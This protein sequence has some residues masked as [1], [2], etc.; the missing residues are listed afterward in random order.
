MG[1]EFDA[2]I[3]NGTWSLCPRPD[4]FHVVRNKWVYKIK[5][6]PEGQIDRYKARLVAKGFDQQY[7]IDYFETFSPVIKPSTIRVVLSLAVAFNWP[8]KQ[9][10]VSNAFLHGFLD[11]EVYME[12]PQGFIDESRP[13]Y[14][15][16]LHK[17][18]YGLKQAPRAWFQRFSTHL[19]DIG[20]QESS[21]DH[22]LFTLQQEKSKLFV[23]VYVDDIIV[24]GTQDSDIEDFIKQLQSTFQ[25]R[26]LGTLSYFIG[27]QASRN[28]EGLY[29]K[30]SK[31]ISDLLDKT[32]MIGARPLSTPTASG[33]KLSAHEGELLT[34]P[35]E[36]RQV[37]GALQYCTL[38]RPDI[39]YAVNQLCQFMHAPRE[40][41]WIATK[42]VL[43][44]LKGTIDYGI[45]YTQST[46]TL[47][48]FCDADWAGN[49]D[50]R[51]STSGYVV[52]LGQ[53]LISWSAKK[54]SV[55][56]KSST[57]AEYR[58]MALV[59]AELYWLRMLL[60]DLGI[61]L[62][63]PPTL[64]CDNVGAISL[65]SN[66]VFHAR[67]KHIEVDYHFI[68]EKVL[69]KDILVRYISTHD[70]IA[71]VFTKGHTTARFM[72]LRSK[73]MVIPIPISLQGNVK[74]KRV[75]VTKIQTL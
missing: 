2:L 21:V 35:T 69:N 15:C 10:D 55:V 53:N 70:Q 71:D 72:F 62:S 29:L 43:R 42:R 32:Q 24:T 58:S 7:G 1:R 67:T 34:D 16:R 54:Q 41:H 12:Q 27:I 64:W 44:Y 59:T 31:Y 57:E 6:T 39:S 5:R 11:E 36:Y 40:P 68:R 56:S 50:D 46:T 52:F 51:K 48:A 33:P 63:S 60:Q 75:T 28:T 3:A 13:E 17:S 73:L 8:I 74:H 45:H 30:Q 4:K 37:I 25:V 18:L 38:T 9:L 49:P 47:D 26:H 61:S 20:F 23:L 14:V 65:A 66:P 19:L 22:S